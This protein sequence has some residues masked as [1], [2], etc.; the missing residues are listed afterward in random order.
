MAAHNVVGA[1]GEWL[2]T[3]RLMAIGEVGESDRADLRIGDVDVE[4]KAARL[5]QVSQRCEG[6]QFCLTRDG[7][8]GFDAEFLV[9]VCFDDELHEQATYVIPAE[10]VGDR[11]KTSVC[12]T[13]TYEEQG[14]W[15]A[16]RDRWDLIAAVC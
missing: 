8:R 7:R 11:R 6:Y 4:V 3:R 5:T 12:L 15:A 1:M 10:A 9:L 14:L 2:V 16:Y 13:E